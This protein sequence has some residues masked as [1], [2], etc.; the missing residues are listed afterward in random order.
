M[1]NKNW[2]N[3]NW[4]EVNLIVYDLQ[5]KIFKASVNGSSNIARMRYYQK[6]L[7]NSE[8]AK[9]VAVRKITQD[10]RGKKIPGVD[11]KLFL[12]NS[13]KIK[14]A[15][16]IRLDGSIDPIRRV[17]IVKGNSKRA[18]GILTLKDR[19]KQILLKLALEPEWEARF[20]P[21]SF[22]YRPGYSAA[23]AKWMLTRQIQGAPKYYLDTD[24]EGCFDNISHEYL[25]T[26]LNT[27]KMF[28]NQI[29]CWLKAGILNSDFSTT[30]GFSES[31]VRTPVGGAMSPLLMNIALDGMEQLLK[32]KFK[33]N[34]CLIRYADNF[35]VLSKKEEM[36][37]E[38][39]KLLLEFLKPLNLEFSKEKTKIGNTL[40]GPSPGFDFL[41][42]NF[43][44]HQVSTHRGVKTTR[45]VKQNFIQ[46]TK[47]SRSSI[48]E[49]KREI[50]ALLKKYKSAQLVSIVDALSE[51]VRS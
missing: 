14:L 7:V 2:K 4:S 5:C 1:R 32:D 23:D 28:E 50:I 34:V 6:T 37:I 39:K 38:S 11:G 41:G 45:G 19:A 36:I 10:N 26:K 29:R 3:I 44:N 22:G 17:Y 30:T 40:Q 21:N 24:V 42:F 33:R 13:E 43:R 18:L 27:I 46:I 25:L 48:K 51:K 49:H 35:V 8:E 15:Y 47:P 12:S 31:C 20:D 16:N 9:L